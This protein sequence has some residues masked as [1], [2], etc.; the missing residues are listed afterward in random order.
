MNKNRDKDIK[1]SLKSGI[2]QE[3]SLQ[4]MKPLKG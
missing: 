1:I 4:I 3:V 2:K